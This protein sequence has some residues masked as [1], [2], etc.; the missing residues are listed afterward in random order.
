MN[1]LVIGGSG[2]IGK[3]AIRDLLS[4]GHVVFNYDLNKYDLDNQN[5]NMIVGD[6]KKIESLDLEA[7]VIINFAAK[8]GGIH[9][10]HKYP[11]TLL[12]ENE[13]ICASVFEYAKK[14]HQQNKGFKKIIQLS[15]SMVF[16]STKVYPSLETDLENIPPPKSVYGF[17][18][19]ASEFWCKAYN[20]EFGLPYVIARPFNAV[21][22]GEDP[23]KDSHVI[24]QLIY[25]VLTGQRPLEIIG[26]GNQI[27][28]YTH[29]SDVASAVRLIAEGKKVNLSY[30]VSNEDNQATVLE[31]AQEICKKISPDEEIMIA[32]LP[33]LKYDVQKRIGRSAKIKAQLGWE[34][35]VTLSQALDEVIEEVKT[36]L[37]NKQY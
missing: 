31:L 26:R 8:L 33:D 37:A 1:I 34:P 19:L 28:V 4:H 21:G 20:E 9:Y 32:N 25:K 18:K 11:A 14:I 12:L 7:E 30:N 2:F 24:P 5:Y 27:R 35:R 10:F 36:C 15:S 23:T 13:L 22:L 16:E 17:Q 29:A 3:Y 6:A